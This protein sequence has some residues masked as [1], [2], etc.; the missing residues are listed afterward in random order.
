M[1]LILIS[2]VVPLL[3]AY[4]LISSLW[5]IRPFSI[6][7]F[8]VKG[9]LS[10]GLSFGITSCSF[11]IWLLIFDTPNTTYMITEN[12]FLLSVLFIVLFAL[13][14]RDDVNTGHAFKEF[15]SRRLMYL[16]GI[17][18]SVILACSIIIFILRTLNEPHGHWDAWA[19]WNMRARFLFRA[20]ENCENAL[21]ALYIWADD[22]YPLLIPGSVARIW[23]YLGSESLAVSALVAFSFTFATVTLIISSLCLMRSISVGLLAGLVLLG[24]PHFV[25]AGAYQIADTPLSFYILSTVV[26]FSLK[27]KMKS[28]PELVLGAGFMAGFAAWTKNEG[29]LFILAVIIA[30]MIVA[31]QDTGIRNCIAEISIFLAGLLP[32]LIIIATFKIKLAPANYLF[33]G[34]SVEAVI[35]RLTD[36]SRSY[37]IGISYIT[38][39]YKNIVK[40]WIII[41]PIFFILLGR[42]RNRFNENCIRSTLTVLL[43][44]LCGYFAIFLITPHD[45]VWQLNTALSRLF[46]QLWPTALFLCF[47]IIPIPEELLAG[48]KPK[49]SRFYP[50]IW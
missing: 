31:L 36:I 3:S 6:A 25:E 48:Y 27:D 7:Q 11:F 12:I 28:N 38:I 1:M 5:T 42:S 46:I 15:N 10:T 4:L 21:S 47:L 49:L 33:S 29:I 17:S 41:L 20:A 50:I 2:F 44:M 45:L 39:F 43:I 22:D 23:C 30:R 37:T 34:L 14:Q 40:N 24:T 26:L 32:I 18:F 13:R 9:S 16:L 8:L 19:I 35:E